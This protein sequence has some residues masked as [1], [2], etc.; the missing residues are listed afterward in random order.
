MALSPA[1]VQTLVKKGFTINVESNAGAE[2][3]FTNADYEAAGA[4]IA[5]KKLAFASDIV[6]KVRGPMVDEVPLFKANS[7]LISFLYPAQNK[8]LVDKLAKKKLNVFAVD[9]VPRISRAQ[10]N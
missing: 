8:D 1:A 2:A 3:Q 10:G 7:T 6:L 4:K 5:D 9:C